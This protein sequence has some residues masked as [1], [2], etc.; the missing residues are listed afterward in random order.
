MT[1][2]DEKRNQPFAYRSRRSR[3]EDP[4]VSIQYAMRAPRLSRA[5]NA[6]GGPPILDRHYAGVGSATSTS[7]RTSTVPTRADGM[8]A[9]MAIASSRSLASIRK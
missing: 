1:A 9:A 7:G 4:H 2:G 3:K 5:R 6:E 8:R